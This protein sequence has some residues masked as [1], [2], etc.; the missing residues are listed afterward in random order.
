MTR[1]AFSFPVCLL[2]IV[3]ASASLAGCN[4]RNDGAPGAGKPSAE[5]TT[6]V[7]A[8][9]PGASMPRPKAGSGVAP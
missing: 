8:T 1:A 5:G 6:D 3:L 9:M 2:T 7:P 4:N